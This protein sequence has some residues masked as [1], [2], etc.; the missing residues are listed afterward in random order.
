MR[1]AFLTIS[2]LLLMA[3]SGCLSDDPGAGSDSELPDP[4]IDPNTLAEDEY[5]FQVLD[6]NGAFVRESAWRIVTGTGNCCENYVTVTP[7]GRI[8]DFGGTFIHYS[9]DD[10]RNWST[11]ETTLPYQNGEGAI[12]PAPGGD[13]VGIGWDP[14]SGDQVYAHKYEA[15]TEEWSYAVVPIHTPFWD[16]EWIVALPGPFTVEGEEVEYITLA[17][18]G[19]GYKEVILMST[20]GLDYQQV[21]LPDFQ[22]ILSDGATSIAA[23]DADP[24]PERDW[25]QPLRQTTISPV[26]NGRAVQTYTGA[27]ASLAESSCNRLFDASATWS[28]LELTE[29]T[30]PD[31]ALLMDSVGTLHI[32]DPDQDGFTYHISHDGGRSWDAT[33][34]TLPHGMTVNDW[35]FKANAALDQTLINIHAATTNDTGQDLVYRFTGLSGIPEFQEI[36]IVGDGQAEVGGGGVSN[37]GDRFDFSNVAMLPDGRIVVSMQD[38][39]F[40][41]EGATVSSNQGSSISPVLAIELPAQKTD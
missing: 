14:Y 29:A 20:N 30:L 2:T 22:V 32:V 23:F 19:T 13:V 34:W 35:D 36:L 26:G 27:V 8:L 11:V 31:G 4:F 39:R 9:D 38:S 1:I 37:Q 15:D 17:R 40:S 25:I 28:C 3:F 5:V 7:T 41:S 12:I 6:A 16:R 10:G 24:D 18:G 21:S 33:E